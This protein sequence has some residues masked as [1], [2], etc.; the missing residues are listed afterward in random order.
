MRG[1]KGINLPLFWPFAHILL[2]QA[3][4]V[5]K[6]LEGVKYYDSPIDSND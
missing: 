3:L 2:I 4:E 5:N 6:T 1:V